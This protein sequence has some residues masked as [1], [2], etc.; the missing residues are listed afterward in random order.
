MKVAQVQA[1]EA[2]ERHQKRK[3]LIAHLGHLPQ[4]QLCEGSETLQTAC[5]F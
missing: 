2:G 1:L 3:A 5:S 4:A